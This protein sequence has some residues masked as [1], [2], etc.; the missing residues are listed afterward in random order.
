VIEGKGIAGGAC[1]QE[2]PLELNFTL[3]KQAK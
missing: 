3:T 1:T 2:Q